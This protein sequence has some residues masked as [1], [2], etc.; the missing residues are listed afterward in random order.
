[1]KHYSINADTRVITANIARLTDK[2]L[3]EVQKYVALGFKIED[4]KPEEQPKSKRL[5]EDYILKY[6]DEHLTAEE[7]EKAKAEYKKWCDT[8]ACDDSGKIKTR[9]YKKT[10]KV[11]TI[12]QGFNAGR[13][14][15]AKT[16]PL[17]I[18]ELNLPE[19]VKKNI[20]ES[21]EKYKDKGDKANAKAKEANLK[22]TEYLNETEYTRYYYWTKI[23]T[24]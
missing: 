17:D 15:F 8:P 12:T 16:Y 6:L 20:A 14:W 9:T 23:F 2:E 13:N 24:K 3:S 5:N 11:E 18:A 1:M 19:A 7:A 4:G 10:K 22:T 21:Y